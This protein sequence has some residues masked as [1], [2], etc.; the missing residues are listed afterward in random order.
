MGIPKS[1][2]TY[3]RQ[4]YQKRLSSEIDDWLLVLGL[5]LNNVER[6]R[7]QDVYFVIGS[8]LN[9]NTK[10]VKFSDV[11]FEMVSTYEQFKTRN[12]I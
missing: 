5:G 3:S 12:K 8:R 1:C 6:G 11:T 10:V 9:N 4:K 7:T 2:L